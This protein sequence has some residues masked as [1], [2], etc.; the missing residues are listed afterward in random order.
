M[1]PPPLQRSLIL[2]SDY[3][4]SLATDPYTPSTVAQSV[5]RASLPDQDAADVTGTGDSVRV[6]TQHKKKNSGP[7]ITNYV[8]ISLPTKEGMFVCVYMRRMDFF[9]D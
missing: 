5:H 8:E 6:V 2:P 9:V 7:A 3:L 1:S 4:L